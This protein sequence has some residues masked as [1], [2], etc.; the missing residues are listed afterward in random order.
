[1]RQSNAIGATRARF[2]M[3][4]LVCIVTCITY[5]ERANL[6]VAAPYIQEELGLSPAMLGVVFSAFG[7]SYTVMQIPSGWFLDRF[8][9][10]LIYAVALFGRSILS[11]LITFSNS[12]V[13]LSGIRFGVGLFESPAFP[14]NG[15][16]VTAWFPAKERGIAIASYIGA[17]YIGLA[18]LTPILT[19]ILVAFGWRSIFIISG[20]LGM[21]CVA[22]WYLYYRDPKD[23]CS[24]N[25]AERDYIHQ[26]GGLSDSLG[27]QQKITWKD[28]RHLFKYRQ[29]WGMYIG[30]FAS[31]SMLFFFMTWFPSYL[32]TSKGMVMLTAGFYVAT[33]F[34]GAITGVLI[35]GKWSDWMLSRGCSLGIA[36]KLPITTGLL[37]S[38]CIIAANYTNNVNLVISI[39]CVA[40]FGQGMSST[41]S[42]ALLSDIA[43]RELIG[44]TGGVFN[45]FANLGGTITPLIIGF[46]I[47]E[48]KSYEIA[49]VFVASIALVGVLACVFII[50]K[51]YR[52][53]INET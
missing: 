7:W 51:P 53:E 32:V 21:I 26:G 25:Q 10:R 14:A 17:Q 1:M 3:L 43:P 23:C 46:I 24:M 44:L 16:I 49:L 12:V 8:G 48:T 36:R 34:L 38:C 31:T 28:A 18:F 30:V 13:I 6:A 33:P 9:S 39:M 15:R 11:I 35:G 4:F 52:I 50:G 47:N 2:F 5:L 22:V 20:I 42:W 19:W 37:I 45:F 29:L 40:F 27:E 41:V